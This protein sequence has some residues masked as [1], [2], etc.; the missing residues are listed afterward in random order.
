MFEKENEWYCSKCKKYIPNCIDI[1]YHENTVH[2]NMSNE[3]VSSW[4]KNGKKG[5]SPYD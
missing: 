3:Y 5:S 4:Y 2:P 1:D